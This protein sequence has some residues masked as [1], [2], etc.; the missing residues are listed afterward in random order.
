MPIKTLTLIGS[1]TTI[2]SSRYVDVA[3]RCWPESECPPV[4]TTTLDQVF[5]DASILNNTA[6]AWLLLD[7]ITPS[8]LHGLVGVLQD[9]HLPTLLSR[10][11]ETMPIGT[12]FQEGI[13]IAPPDALPESLCAAM[14]TLWNQAGLVHSLKTE[15]NFLQAHHGGL[16]EQIDKIDEELRLAAQLQREFLPQELPACR[17]VEFK[18]LYRPA[19]YVS[20]DIYDVMRLDEHHIGFFLADAAGHGVPAALMTMYIKRS[21]HT[22][23][24][25]PSTPQGYRIIPPDEALARLNTDML[26]KQTGK[27]RFATACYGVIDCR[28]MEYSLARAGHPFPLCIHPDGSATTFEPDGMLL[29]VFPNAQFEL[30][31]GKLTPGDRVVIYSDGF[32][33][34]FPESADSQNLHPSMVNT[35]YADEFRDLANGPLDQAMQRLENKLD[36]QIGSLNQRDDLTALCIGALDPVAETETTPDPSGRKQDVVKAL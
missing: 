14:R 29:G 17:N 2:L 19:G 7:E 33:I 16:C 31:H 32:E 13:V 21:L 4:L 25:D 15:V 28:T 24:I 22:K 36:Q 1:N 30:T 3:L 5:K 12:P 35:R 10:A 20:G 18:V 27:T 26:R 34:A 9:R 23:E 8:A 11:D 6:M